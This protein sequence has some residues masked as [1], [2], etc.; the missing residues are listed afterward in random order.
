[1]RFGDG[2]IRGNLDVVRAKIGSL[3]VIGEQ[4]GRGEDNGGWRGKVIKKKAES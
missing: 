1:M 4:V 2:R 3:G